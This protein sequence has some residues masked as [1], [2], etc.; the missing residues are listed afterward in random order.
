[1]LMAKA[2]AF[3]VFPRPD[4][5][6]TGGLENLSSIANRGQARLGKRKMPDHSE[7]FA[8]EPVPALPH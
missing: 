4:S 3:S 5:L 6:F 7:L 1:M 2:I 8:A